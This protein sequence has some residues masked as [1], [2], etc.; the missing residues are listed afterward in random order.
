MGAFWVRDYEQNKIL[1]S[2]KTINN[3]WELESPWNIFANQIG[4]ELKKPVTFIFDTVPP[5]VTVTENG[6]AVE[7]GYKT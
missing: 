5:T 7:K 6:K 3:I 4:Y 1:D 2:E